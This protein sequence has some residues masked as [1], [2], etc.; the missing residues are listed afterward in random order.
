MSPPAARVRACMPRTVAARALVLAWCALASCEGAT[1]RPCL[2]CRGGGNAIAALAGARPQH[3]L[4]AGG[5][6]GSF[7]VLF[8]G[9]GVSTG[10]PRIGCIVRPDQSQPVCRVCRDALRQGSRNRRGNVSIL[11]RFWHA[12]GRPRHIMV[13]GN[14]P[15][16][17]FMFTARAAPSWLLLWRAR[18]CRAHGA[19]LRAELS[20]LAVP[21]IVHLYRCRCSLVTALLLTI[22]L[23]AG[24]RRQDDARAVH[25]APAA[26]WRS[27]S[28]R[29][30]AHTRP[31]R[32]DPRA[33]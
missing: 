4:G 8:L 33:R 22:P 2:A 29:A 32:R 1:V 23:L 20:P 26:P 17:A 6:P 3:H 19:C 24:G 5:P 12:D 9:S 27:Q 25:Q 15:V 14:C 18:G 11:V 16:A 28:R 21:A 30:A 31:C 7:D 13:G 10:V